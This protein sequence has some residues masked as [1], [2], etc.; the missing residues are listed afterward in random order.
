MSRLLTLFLEICL[1]RKGPQDVPS[2]GFLVASTAALG[3]L[4][5]VI[6]LSDSF[7]GPGGALAAQL[8]DL[9]LLTGFIYG[10]LRFVGSPT[11]LYQSLAALFG[12][13]TLINVATMLVLAFSKPAEDG[14][15]TGPGGML[16]L[17]IMTW[18]LVVVAHILRHTFD[19][20]FLGGIALAIAYFLLINSLVQKLFLV[21]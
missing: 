6:V 13:G 4:S 3:L 5:G 8:L 1:L 2:S 16:Y 19:I 15:L 9:L 7:Q 21:G 14:V 12:S 20:A 18:A 17:F 10:G 11:R